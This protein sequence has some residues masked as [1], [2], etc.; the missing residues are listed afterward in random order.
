M[1]NMAINKRHEIER[2]RRQ[3]EEATIERDCLFAENRRLSRFLNDS[4]KSGEGSG[5]GI[6]GVSVHPTAV[7]TSI[8]QDSPLHQKVH[9]FG[10]FFRGR[11]DVFPRLWQ[12]KRTLRMGYSPV[13][14]REWDP[15][16]CDKPRVKCGDC[17]NR[18]FAPMTDDV[19][20]QHL[21]GNHTIGIYPLLPE[22][23]CYLLVLDFDKQSWME[24]AAAFM[25]TCN[26][27][28]VPA[29]L[30]PI[31]LHGITLVHE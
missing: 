30:E 28:D 2:L 10:S 27:L 12:N 18:N 11:E 20:R 29:A 5:M 14:T 17:P 19:I 16:Y 6:T 1:F 23:T 26:R 13:C 15:L 4:Q 31:P 25:E 24:D 8:N 7:L 21:E 9:L 3:L 22:E